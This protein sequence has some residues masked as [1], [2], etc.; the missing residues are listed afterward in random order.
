MKVL[1][2]SQNLLTNPIFEGVLNDTPVGWF[3]NV[4]G[5]VAGGEW[6][7]PD[8][9]QT[10][11]YPQDIDFVDE[12]NN[13]KTYTKV[14]KSASVKG[15]GIYRNIPSVDRTLTN[16]FKTYTDFLGDT[17]SK[18]QNRYV[19]PTTGESVV[20]NNISTYMEIETNML[21]LPEFTDDKNIEFH[22]LKTDTS[23][24]LEATRVYKPVSTNFSFILCN[25]ESESLNTFLKTCLKYG[26]GFELEVFT[27]RDQVESWGNFQ[28]GNSDWG[29]FDAAGEWVKFY[30]VDINDY[31]INRGSVV[32][33]LN[34][35]AIIQ[36]SE[37]NN[38]L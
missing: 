14:F 3:V 30:N 23:K 10:L 8:A 18:L 19:E 7:L 21:R 37:L 22:I 31:S 38:V 16:E 32:S 13:F 1:L 34:I 25:K 27:T 17:N 5:G 6:T 29:G 11:F 9:N 15:S 20:I 33:E 2:R 36:K 28:W 35:S 24:R 26:V 4:K 12:T